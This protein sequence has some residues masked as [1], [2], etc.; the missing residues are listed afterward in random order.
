MAY[1]GVDL[2]TGGCRC[3]VVNDAGEIEA[4]ASAPLSCINQSSTPGRSEQS[5]DDWIGALE[6]CLHK[7]FTLPLKDNIRSIS[8]DGTSGTVLPVSPSGQALAFA[9]MHNDMRSVEEA[10]QCKTVFN[11]DCSPTFALPK[12][13]WMQK[14]LSLPKDTLFMHASDFLFA[15]LAGK[16]VEPNQTELFLIPFPQTHRCD[17]AL[18]HRDQVPVRAFTQGSQSGQVFFLYSLDGGLN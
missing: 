9:L 13:L 8:I 3:V 17:R 5:A 6:I 7:I 12:I 11:G 4:E 10:K 14:N 16:K 15:W 18:H 2:G 1:L